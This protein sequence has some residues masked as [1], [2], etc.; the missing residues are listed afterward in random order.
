METKY[1]LTHSELIEVFKKWDEDYLN[2][3]PDAKIVKPLTASKGQ[4]EEFAKLLKEV[5]FAEIK[6]GV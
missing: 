4:A 5:Q 3:Y 2:N 6:S 1:E